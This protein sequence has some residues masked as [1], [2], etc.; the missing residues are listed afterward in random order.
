[1]QGYPEKSVLTMALR[2]YSINNNYQYGPMMAMSIVMS[3][4]III[5]FCFTQKYFISGV[6]I[7]GIKG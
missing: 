3:V 6:A 5:F 7:G 1:L 2:N 4:P